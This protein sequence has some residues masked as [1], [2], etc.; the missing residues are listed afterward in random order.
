MPVAH[1]WHGPKRM[2]KAVVRST[3]KMAPLSYDR[4]AIFC[5]YIRM[6]Y[7]ISATA[8]ML[9]ENIYSRYRDGIV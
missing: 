7:R 4:R 3:Y 2:G 5:L 1:V 6:K 8:V 9:Q